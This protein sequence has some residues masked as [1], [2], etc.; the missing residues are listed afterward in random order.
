M[1]TQLTDIS[2]KKDLL[3]LNGQQNF[4]ILDNK[5]PPHFFEKIVTMEMELSEEFNHDKLLSLF[6][7]YLLAI[8]YYSLNDPPK[9]K[10]YKLR[11]ENYFT[12][13]E[14]LKNLNKFNQEKK[15]GKESKP[16]Y[17]RSQTAIFMPKVRERTKTKLKL[18]SKGLKDAEIR[19]QVRAVLKDVVYLMKIDKKNLRD[20]IKDDLQKQRQNWLENMT[21]KKAFLKYVNNRR[22][23]IAVKF[24]APRLSIR[25]SFYSKNG[26][27]KKRSFY[28]KNNNLAPDANDN[29]E[30][31][32]LEYLNLLNE[33]EG[34]DGKNIT[35]SDYGD[36]EDSEDFED[37]EDSE[38]SSEEDDED[39]DKD[40]DNKR[41]KVINNNFRRSVDK[42]LD[43]NIHNKL[44]TSIDSIKKR[45]VLSA[46]KQIDE[47][48]E[49]YVPDNKN[50]NNYIKKNILENIENKK[51]YNSSKYLPLLVLTNEEDEKKK[52]IYPRND[53]ALQ[54]DIKI[55]EENLKKEENTKIEDI[56]KNEE[57][58]KNEEDVKNE[59]NMKN[60]E[61]IKKEDN[62]LLSNI[63]NSS[64]Y[65][66]K[67]DN[68]SHTTSQR[69]KSIDTENVIRAI[70]IDDEITKF[71]DEKIK[72]IDNLYYGIYSDD[73]S[74]F[75]S[76]RSI[77]NLSKK[78]SAEIPSDCQATYTKIENR[79][80]NYVDNINKYFYKE[81]FDT[82]FVKLKELYKEKY[83]NYL[84][85]NNEYHS[86]IKENE[87]NLE[88]NDKISEI[89]KK[90]IQNI[91]DSLKE[92]Q[93]DQIDKI[94]D[95]YNTKIKKFINDFKQNLFKKNV[96]VDLIEEQLKL[97]IYT[98][99]NDAIYQIY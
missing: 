65:E 35:D 16:N 47:K 75:E 80:K 34:G 87:Y 21:E 84:K 33:V 38:E 23:T 43:F 79:A 68:L 45:I 57:N 17:R 72:V 26:K 91:I 6:Q 41:N 39:E 70:K 96:G 89:E 76:S 61:N 30:N 92:E 67:E 31:D 18:E 27:L 81:M 56:L 7:L 5:L 3:V 97:D 15:E 77:P 29:I 69:R 86:N 1:L 66:K 48:E 22:K 52:K 54:G 90:E 9:A 85:V 51:K 44:N 71:L 12:E 37:S 14:T 36:S 13:K 98:I 82:F 20:I 8:Q 28:Y 83:E 10:P 88:C 93:K 24:N 46:L 59:E 53:T 25:K 55:E 2:K 64:I 42:A 11:M 40:N 50:N 63:N 49:E 94:V 78:T 60:E 19:N 32:D 95:E 73:E 58:V 99:I 74:N 62:E 4:E